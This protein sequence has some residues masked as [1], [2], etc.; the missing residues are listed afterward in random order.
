MFKIQMTETYRGFKSLEIGILDL[1][2]GYWNLG[3]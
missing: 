2:F 3:F 1:G